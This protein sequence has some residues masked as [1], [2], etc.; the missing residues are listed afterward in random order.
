MANWNA[1]RLLTVA[2]LLAGAAI[3]A[4]AQE[5]PQDQRTALLTAERNS[6]IMSRDSGLS[7]A[8]LQGMRSEGVLLWPGAP[9]LVGQAQLRKLFELPK[10]KDSAQ[11]IWQPLAAEISKDSSL[12]VTWGVAAASMRG[13]PQLGRYIMTW[14]R[15]G[16]QWKMSALALSGVPGLALDSAPAGIPL[17]RKALAASGPAGPIV[18]AD[19]AFAKLAGDSGAAIAF[20]HWAAPTATIFANRGMLTRGPDEIGQAVD[21]PATWQW[22]P[23][24]ADVARSG[25]LGWTVGEAIIS[26]K[27]EEPNYSK[28]LTV[29]A[30]MPDGAIRFLT[31]GGNARPAAA[32]PSAQARK[33]K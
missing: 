31:D 19:L 1:G 9:V 10:I 5:Q 33:N 8:L 28:Y 2:T 4:G 16:S 30:R 7:R 21:G 12:G 14:R 17:T 27:G 26:A 15:D 22:H 13:A 20:S 32:W 24:A 3:Q 23:V 25:D 6:A 18:A 29:W 11:L